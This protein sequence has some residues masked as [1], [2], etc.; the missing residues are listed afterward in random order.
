M[1]KTKRMLSVLLALALILAGLPMYSMEVQAE[2][3]FSAKAN[4][5]GT[6]TIEYY[7]GYGGEVT[8]PSEINGKKV[9][10]IKY[11]AFQNHKNLISVSLPDSVTSIG[12]HAFAGCSSLVSVNIPD[13]VTDIGY[14]TFSGCSSLREINIPSGVTRIDNDTFSG[15]SSLTEISIPSG[16]H[17]IHPNAFAG[18]S[19]LAS[20]KVDVDNATFESKDDSG[21]DCNAIIETATNELVLGCKNTKFPSGVTRIGDYAFMGRSGLT[22]ISIPDGVTSI[23]KCAFSGCS[24]LR[25]IN[26]PSEVESIRDDTFSYCSSLAVIEVDEGNETYYSKDNSKIDCNAIIKKESKELVLG[27]KNTKFPSGVTR[28]GAY[29]FSSCSSLTEVSIPSGVTSIGSAAFKNCSNLTE[30][31]IP[32]SVT[33]IGM[34]VFSSC[35]S[36]AEISIPD[37]VT[38]IGEMAFSGCS[39]LSRINIPSG[40][41]RIGKSAFSG[42]SSLSK[43]NIPDSMTSIKD[44]TFSGCSSLAEIS[45]PSGV[46]SIGENAFKNCSSLT[47]ISIPSGV[48]SIGKS[49]FYGCNSLAGIK[50]DGA[51]TTY[52]SREDCNAIIETASNHLIYGCK[53]TKIPSGVTSIGEG[54][55]LDCSALTE[56]SIPDSVTSIGKSAFSGCSSLKG[57]IIP[58][59]VTSI[60]EGAFWNCSGLEEIKVAEGNTVYDSRD[61][62]NA[63]IMEEYHELVQITDQT[64]IIGCKNTKIPSGV[65][66]IGNDAFNGCTSL[67]EISIPSGVTNISNDAFS[68]CSGLAEVSI[69][70]S[71]TGI[72]NG[73]FLGCSSLTEIRVPGNLVLLGVD[74]LGYEKYEQRGEKIK[75]PGFVIYGKIGTMIE[76]HADIHGF[77]F[78]SVSA[79]DIGWADVVL[80]KDN[81]QYDGEAKTPAVT[82]MMSGETLV[83]DK[84]YTVSYSNNTVAGTAVV[85]VTG[86]RNYTGS[87][88]KKYTISKADISPGNA[89]HA[90]VALEQESYVYD[91][92][93]KTPAVTV[94]LSGKTL[95]PDRDYT[96]SYSNN[97]AAGTAKVTVT[98]T[99]I[100]TGNVEKTYTIS[101]TA[102][103]AATVALECMR[104]DYDGEAKTPAVTV[105]L[106][107]KALVLNRD[108]T[109]SYSSNT[110]AGT[111]KVTVTGIG[112]CTGNVE[113]PY[114]ISKINLFNAE[115]ILETE[116]YVYDGKAKTPSVT[117]TLSGKELVPGRDYTIFYSDNT[118]VGTAKV[119]VTGIGS[120][121][122]SRI[123]NFTI[124]KSGSAQSP[125]KA[126]IS[127]AAVTL[128]KT[129]YVYDGK[130]KTPSVTVTLSGET[131]VPDKDYTVSYSNNINIGTATVTV[132]GKG[133]YT[134]SKK[135]DFTIV[136]AGE[137]PGGNP[138]G[139]PGENPGRNPGG[140]PG[141]NPGENPGENPGGNPGENPGGNPGGNPGENPGQNPGS[142]VICKK[143]IYK[144][145]Y[146][147]KPFKINATSK[148]KLTFISS[149]P[150]IASVDKSTGKVT[151]K[152][153]GVVTITVKAGSNT[154]KVFVKV[155]PKKASLKSVKVSKGKKLKVKWAKDKMA[156]GYQVQVSTSRNFKK[157]MKKKNVKKSSYK[158]RK[159]K[160]GKKYYVRVRSYKKVGKE[161]LYGAWSKV[162]KSR[163]VN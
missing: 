149:S 45:I 53:N 41:T 54:A 89:S 147:A 16:V 95:V 148:R 28:I 97:T 8:V 69:P 25:E 22:E 146:G 151:I 58:S 3:Q 155:S 73:A 127:E 5:D 112:S 140:N 157:N 62:C 49:A 65:T 1:K 158:F 56:I 118:D 119:T 111:A 109:V 51:N 94:T 79:S 48:T 2:S 75:I 123:A 163:K 104:Y 71:V 24:D 138:G 141:G 63:V 44:E 21:N 113:E 139:N 19:S 114:Y 43:I 36:L 143:T 42:C 12:H 159:L 47:E 122:G 29:A 7:T 98:G 60:G 160:A 153:T 39:S 38:Y 145:A 126:D 11:E 135:V 32:D 134:G 137:N 83:P 102:L 30:I 31:S 82:V 52:D 142:S 120:C 72:G 13:G 67:T 57:I 103:S 59:G 156:S 27:C 4:D 87:V 34:E 81:Y 68:G 150:K 106:S 55:F 88:K 105:T 101:K 14:Y 26:I 107:G 93:A 76:K 124:S 70:D 162:K 35:S 40:V 131:L 18:C 78:I 110:A 6:I 37:N 129:S 96:V 23:G 17:S 128:D 9:T 46:A 132:T 20:I 121:S 116:S 100:Y 91:G 99:G 161:T 115:V 92:K 136:K 108:Y 50:I 90:E 86:I 74:A 33:G 80:E 144:V 66:K 10:C 130:A 84:D 117:V 85:T 154:V 61:N 152:G 125:D 133:D 64:L 15:C 77:T